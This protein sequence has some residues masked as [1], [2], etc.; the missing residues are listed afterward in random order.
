[1]GTNYP[2]AVDSLTNPAAG[3][4]LNSPSHAAQHANAND[5]IEAVQ[6]EL[7]ANPSGS[8]ATVVARL[9]KIEDG[10]RLGANSVGTTQIAAN[11]VG[12]SEL[13]DN[14]VDTNAIA[15]S[16]VTSAKIADG[17]IVA[18]DVAASTFA[19]FGTVGNLLTANQASGTDT[20]ADTTGFT[21][22]SN[23]SIAR[24]TSQAAAGSGCLL[25]GVGGE[26][27]AAYVK[28]ATTEGVVGGE[29][30][31]FTLRARQDSSAT[32]VHLRWYWLDASGTQIGG[33]TGTVG[34]TPTTTWQ[35]LTETAVAPS[36]AAKANVK[37]TVVGPSA[38][39]G[40]AFIDCFGL[41]RGASGKWAM[42]GTPIPGQSRIAVN[43]AVDLSGT[44]SP[45][46]VVTAAPGS[47]W[48][49]TDSTTDVKGWIKWIKATGT[50]N[51]GWVVGPE[52]DTGWRNVAALLT[53]DATA[54]FQT[55][56]TVHL[57]RVG[58]DVHFRMI[59]SVDAGTAGGT[60]SDLTTI[61]LPSGFRPAIYATLG[62]VSHY[63]A[64][65]LAVLTALSSKSQPYLNPIGATWSAGGATV[66]GFVMWPTDEAWPASLPGSAV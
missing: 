47:T 19:A 32:A 34:V 38:G 11:A 33:T 36:N 8:E 6:T 2:G 9:D 41:W 27:A 18:G 51:T 53:A 43:N 58:G 40:S 17:T 48:L 21:N 55:W 65:K 59:A 16:A 12:A 35:T 44:G 46:G 31:T 24:S 39:V 20:L 28:L 10:T 14:A 57:R 56:T 54:K 5:A 13:A 60:S 4:A 64:S 42:P 66:D 30:Y 1:M 22:E 49:Q 25:V 37:V 29:T 63:Y 3:D 15:D 52:A 23:A 50:G 61:T 45:E 7:G 26:A 62:T